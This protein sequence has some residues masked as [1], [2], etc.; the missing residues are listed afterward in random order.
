M[1]WPGN[2]LEINWK[3]VTEGRRETMRNLRIISATNEIRI[4]NPDNLVGNVTSSTVSL[5]FS[6]SLSLSLSLSDLRNSDGPR[7]L[8]VEGVGSGLRKHV[9]PSRQE[10][11]FFITVCNDNLAHSSQRP[12]G[13][14]TSC[15]TNNNP[16]IL[17]TLNAHV[18]PATVFRISY[19]DGL[20][21]KLHA[22][23]E[24]E[25]R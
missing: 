12:R 7:R 3:K 13:F 24:G 23:K 5:Y 15:F 19:L 2:G 4:K 22:I 10:R 9:R 11:Y 18:S 17:V 14:L 6:L 25:G 8:R 21:E 20:I 16:R 1:P